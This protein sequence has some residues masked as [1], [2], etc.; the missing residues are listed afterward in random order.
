MKKPQ[1]RYGGVL[2][3]Q[4]IYAY[5]NVMT[6]QVLYSLTRTLQHRQLKQL[7]DT[8]ANNNPPKLRRDVWRP[9]WSLQLPETPD[10]VAQGLHAYKLLRDF[11]QL[12][13]TSWEPPKSMSTP[14]TAKQIE[15]LEKHLEQG[16]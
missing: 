15:K 16:S 2:P 5:C 14:Y 11:R 3:G 6:N 4:H 12:H 1:A 13:E 8:G 9:L 7:A 10:G